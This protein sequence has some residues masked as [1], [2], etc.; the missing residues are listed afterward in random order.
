[1]KNVIFFLCVFL[2]LSCQNSSSN[3][4]QVVEQSPEYLD[5]E[6]VSRQLIDQ[7]SLTPGENVLLVASP[8]RFDDLIAILARRIDESGGTYLGTLSVTE[9]QPDAWTTGYV[10]GLQ[11][12]EGEVL[13][14]A[15]QTIDLGI[16]MPG[17]TPADLYYK[18][19]Q[20]NLDNGYGRT[21]HFHWSG[22]YDVNGREIPIDSAR[23]VFYQ[24][25]IANT[26]YTGLAIQ[27]RQFEE[28]MRGNEI[29]VT[30]PAGTDIQFSIGD[31]PVTKQD[32]DAS[33]SRA[34]QALNLI[35][36]EIEMPAGAIRTAP[37]ESTVNGTIVFPD[38]VWDSEPVE[39]LEVLIE[40]GMIVDLSADLGLEAVK[41]EMK[42]AGDAGKSFR[43]F[44]LGFNPL[45]SI[46]DRDPWIP[47]YGYGAGIVRLS[48][49]DN[50]ELGGRVTGGYVRWNFFTDATVIVGNDTW[51]EN[52]KLI[53]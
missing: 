49:G 53:R 37:I 3:N 15:L 13:L 47:Y 5:F 6:L 34:E 30:T 10:T 50:S 23:D 45:L 40:N 48:L 27:Q 24:E 52:G 46:P 20:E 31:R 1:M 26:N 33:A 7:M 22:A 29:R 51:V 39:G 9:I 2:T 28:A 42:N 21:I 36:R 32:G 17:P 8:G 35:D 4:D 41:R 18:L 12:L 11:S 16:M 44:A 43:E 19:I 38:G 14:E 25:V